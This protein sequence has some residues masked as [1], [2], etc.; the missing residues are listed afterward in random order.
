MF[1]RLNTTLEIGQWIPTHTQIKFGINVNGEFKGIHYLFAESDDFVKVLD[2]IPEHARHEFCVSVMEINTLIPPHTDSGIKVA[3]NVYLQTEDCVTQFYEFGIDNP[4]T[5]QIGSQ[6]NG[7]IY[8]ES[9]LVESASFI[10]KPGEV[11]VLDVTR[12]HSVKPRGEI[13]KRVAVTLAT[14]AYDFDQV[15]DLLKERGVL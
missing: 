1:D 11:W 6:T 5:Y 3:I 7:A 8:Q 9:D 14:D 4:S 13:K 15:C 10:A 12:P 2:L